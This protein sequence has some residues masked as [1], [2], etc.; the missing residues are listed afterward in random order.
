MLPLN[1]VKVPSVAEEPTWKKTLQACAPL[2]RTTE[3]AVAVVSVDP[4]WNTNK[5]FG[6]FCPSRVSVPVIETEEPAVYVPA[7]SLCP[8]RSAPAICE[9]DAKEAAA[10]NAVIAS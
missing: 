1:V 8:P 7:T 10:L 5:E 2:T 6:L 3:A 9:V 4:I